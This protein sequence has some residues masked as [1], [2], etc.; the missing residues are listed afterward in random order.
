MPIKRK[1]KKKK[2]SF[3]KVRTLNVPKGFDFENVVQFKKAGK[4]KVGV[5][6]TKKIRTK[7]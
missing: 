4:R 7:K 2:T 6:F 1:S 3:V 5:A